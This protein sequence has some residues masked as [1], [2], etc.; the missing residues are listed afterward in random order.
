MRFGIFSDVHSNLPA[1]DAVFAAFTR[2]S[3]DKY[4]C[5]GD[6]VGYAANP[7]ECI[8]KIRQLNPL[9]VAG[10]HDWASVDL[11][12]TR[13]F[14]PIAKEAVEWTKGQ[15]SSEEKKFLKSLELVFTDNNFILVH[16]TLDNP[17]DFNYLYDQLDAQVTFELMAANICFVGHTHIPGV[18]VQENNHI[19][20]HQQYPLI[21]SGQ[22]KYIVNTGS[23]GQPRDRNPQA[24]YCIFDTGTNSLEIKRIDYDVKEAQKMILAAGLP[25]FL[26][27]RLA[28]GR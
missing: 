13:Y 20:Y 18:F 15:L 3:I 11:F 22:K 17:E 21:I 12:N 19:S 8:A 5:I 24:S 10:N 6:M 4:I 28:V 1:L 25:A 7:K 9:L 14:N 16:G 27:E 2:E 26:S 23:V